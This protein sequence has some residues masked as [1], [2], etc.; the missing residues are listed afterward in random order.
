MK[1]ISFYLPQFHEIP[2]ND[3]WWGK[4][5]TEWVN[6]KNAKKLFSGHDQPKEP[7]NDNY[8]NLADYRTTIWQVELAKKYGVS[9]FCYYHYW[10]NGKLLLEKPIRNHLEHTEIDFPFC[11]CWA[12]EPWTRSWDGKSKE[13]IMPQKYG[14]EKEWKAHFNYLIEF[15]KDSRYIKI[16]NKPV[17]LIYRPSSIDNCERMLEY[18]N[19]M[20]IQEGF[21]G[22]FFIEML[23][24]FDNRFV[25][26]FEASV[27]FEPM[28][29]IGH[30]LP[31][32]DLIKRAVKK[33]G[34][35]TLKKIS[36]ERYPSWLL[37]S[38]DY[39][40]IWNLILSRQYRKRRKK[41]Y[42]GAF[43]NWDNTARK[44]R[45]GLILKNFSIDK[46]EKNLSKQ[47]RRSF[48]FDS[49]F[50][51]INAWNEWAEGTYLEPDKTNEFKYLEC[52]KR[53]LNE[54]NIE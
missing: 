24:S 41:E 39:D 42:L 10:F 2:E 30:F 22:I 8:Y 35:K 9:G 50:I 43:V 4:G 18:F 6:T 45:N 11:M 33:I 53:A 34:R 3:K 47:V 54:N 51:F 27:D 38:I 23:T 26:G 7:L 29:T 44:G 49:E 46:F 20:A 21:C 19:N 28:Y 13:I 5:F 52:V 48:K 15:F 17:F 14:S 40:L 36:F 16:E 12:N 31:K 37:D 1:M 32:K 25:K